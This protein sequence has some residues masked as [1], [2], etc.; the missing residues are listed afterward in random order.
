MSNDGKVNSVK[1]VL[2]QAVDTLTADPDGAEFELWT[3][4]NSSTTNQERFSGMFTHDSMHSAIESLSPASGSDSSCYV[5]GFKALG[6]MTEVFGNADLWLFTDGFTYTTL[7]PA[8]AM[9][10]MLQDKDLRASIALLGSCSSLAT[11]GADEPAA[12]SEAVK[13]SYR[14]AAKNLGITTDGVEEGILPY[15]VVAAQ[16]GGQF[17]Y[18]SPTQLDSASEVLLSQITHSAGAGRWSDYV[19]DYST[20]RY[21]RLASWEYSWVDVTAVG[22]QWPGMTSDGYVVASLP[23]AFDYFGVPTSGSVYVYEN[24]YMVLDPAANAGNEK[25]NTSFPNTAVPNNAIYPFWDELLYMAPGLVQPETSQPG[26]DGATGSKLNAPTATG[27]IWEYWGGGDWVIFEYKEFYD[28][29]HAGW[30]T[31]EVMINLVTDEIRFQYGTIVGGAQS[32]TIGLENASGASYV[33]ASYNTT[34]GAQSGMGYKFTPAPAQ[35]T[36][37]YT[38][39]VDSTMSSIGFLM[40]GFS[41][42][43]DPLV[44]LDSDDKIVTCSDP[45]VTCISAGRVQ[46]LQA[47]VNSRYGDWDARVEAGPSGSGTFSFSSFAI[48]AV[49]I[50]DT[51]EH[52]ISTASSLPLYI[53]LGQTTDDSQLQGDF[54]KPDGSACGSTIY[55][56]DDGAH[57]DLYD[58]DGVFGSAAYTPQCTGSAYLQLTGVMTG[59]NIVRVDPKPYLFIP[60]RLELNDRDVENYGSGTTLSYYIHND[61]DFDHTYIY[62]IQLPPGW[63]TSPTMAGEEVFVNAHSNKYGSFQ[64]FMGADPN[65]LASGNSGQVVLTIIEKELGEIT[66]SDSATITRRRAPSTLVFEPNA[67]YLRPYDTVPLLVYINDEQGYPVADG[68]QIDLYVTPTGMGSLPGYAITANGLIS[69]DY[70]AGGDLGTVTITAQYNG[71]LSALKGGPLGTYEIPIQNPEAHTIDLVAADHTL[72]GFGSAQT[73]LTATV[74]DHFGDPVKSVDIEICVLGDQD[75]YSNP[76]WGLVDDTWCVTKT[77]DNLGQV[78]A[79][80]TA[81]YIH[82]WAKIGAQVVPTGDA[83]YQVGSIEDLEQIWLSWYDLYLP[84]ILR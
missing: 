72:P 67:Y 33:Q 32:A 79:L 15:L 81:G 26:L 46:Y 4:N 43:F 66:A 76:E 28:L 25:N 39:A 9:T 52:S 21:D 29:F 38:V 12:V 45:G 48:S 78:Q 36:K 41:G 31:F 77:T 60:V 24:G 7:P 59:T 84:C 63:W 17:L 65:T 13:R 37:T 27:E 40:T 11:K 14:A 20:Y 6:Q 57:N 71:P 22:M 1:T 56:Y 2:Q 49:A 54:V 75:Q 34:S 80:Y 73:W 62:D 74:L 47:P 5:E 55:L 69:F 58:K 3:F 44:V 19:S 10:R 23:L 42:D 18:V 68:L 83:K 61:D 35:P 8:H 82:G 16:S 50:E 70:T 64:V 51:G 30:N 53:D